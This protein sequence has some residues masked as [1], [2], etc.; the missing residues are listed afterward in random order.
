MFDPY[1][2][3]LGIP[4]EQQPPDHHRLLGIPAGDHS[5][6][7]ITEA[8]RQ[9]TV[10]LLEFRTAPNARECARLINEIVEA[11]AALLK[12]A[13]EEPAA[14]R[15]ETLPTPEITPRPVPPPRRARAGRQPATIRRLALAGAALALVLIGVIV[16][17]VAT[18]P[19]QSLPSN[20]VAV[21]PSSTEPIRVDTRPKSSP[22]TKT[23]P[24]PE[25]KKIDPPPT[26]RKPPPD[27][28]QLEKEGRVAELLDKWLLSYD[29]KESG[30]ARQ[31]LE[32]LLKARRITIDH[33]AALLKVLDTKEGKAFAAEALGEIGPAAR[34]A[35]PALAQL[36]KDPLPDL[37]HKALGA[38]GKIGPAKGVVEA[39]VGALA[40]PDPATVLRDLASLGAASLV[41]PLGSSDRKVAMEALTGIPAVRSSPGHS[42][43]GGP[44]AAEALAEF[45]GFGPDDVAWLHDALL[46]HVQ[47]EQVLPCLLSALTKADPAGLEKLKGAVSH[48]CLI[49]QNSKS[50][51]VQRSALI[52]LRA[53]GR[54]NSG[55]N[56]ADTRVLIEKYNHYAKVN[57][58]DLQALTS[59]VWLANANLPQAAD[60]ARFLITSCL[61][62]KDDDLRRRAMAALQK[63]G[64]DTDKG[65]LGLVFSG[66]GNKNPAVRE[67]VKEVLAKVSRRGF[68]LQ[69]ESGVFFH[70]FR[71][72]LTL[73]TTKSPDQRLWA[74]KVLKD[75][76]SF[77]AA[78]NEA[79]LS[80]VREDPVVEIRQAAWD[81]VK[82]KINA[83]RKDRLVLEL[84]DIIT[85]TRGA[86]QRLWTLKL[87]QEVDSFPRLLTDQ[88]LAL[89]LADAS[90]D[91]RKAAWDL[92]R[93]KLD[94][95]RKIKLFIEL[96]SIA[97]ATKGKDNPAR[98]ILTI[99][100]AEEPKKPIPK[101][102]KE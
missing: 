18:R 58:A 84:G 71:A 43:L 81:I 55:T 2:Q 50:E 85:S 5:R 52:A 98:D 67:A 83:T 17:M 7:A 35:A 102:D 8:A 94:P 40:A 16:G 29:P 54:I 86:D 93:D 30:E 3:W 78:L 68:E 49:L 37:R 89:V 21:S 36:A 51:E 82:D 46:Q 61:A 65:V 25:P 101:K 75:V 6:R 45:Q 97:K 77:P 22:D 87:I 15:P 91:V 90:V 100:E 56:N 47:N 57:H 31:A 69:G 27:V 4:P 62:T 13:P 48:I 73:A 28:R 66:L 53:V 64:P 79:L 12:L 74:V 38:L 95:K 26:K 96:E 10:Q 72:S 63:L 99:I 88:I 80:V 20:H 14:P 19:G 60:C 76:G 34:E 44:L 11:R 92:V 70:Q 41:N 42:L 9:R 1:Q 24:D 32:R 39:L 33:V 23:I 59:E